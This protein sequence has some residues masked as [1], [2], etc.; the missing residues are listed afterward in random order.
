MRYC[1]SAAA[2]LAANMKSP[3]RLKRELGKLGERTI[4]GSS[5]EIMS[6]QPAA[7]FA[8]RKT[9]GREGCAAPHG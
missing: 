3:G 6:A 8:E 1:L 7:T 9:E 2:S 5:R 4:R